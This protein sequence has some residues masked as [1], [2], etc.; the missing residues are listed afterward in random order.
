MIFE[1]YGVL[2]MIEC[3]FVYIVMLDAFW[4]CR[5]VGIIV[6]VGRWWPGNSNVFPVGLWAAQFWIIL[7]LAD[8]APGMQKKLSKY[9]VGS[10]FW[11]SLKNAVI[12]VAW[13]R[14]QMTLIIKTGFSVLLGGGN[15]N[16][17]YVHPENWGRWTHLDSYVSKGLVQPPTS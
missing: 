10:R 8:D 14:K 4:C 9:C 13:L 3:F 5:W 11:E 15:S 1:D 12:T 17:F 7:N 6:L 2:L 16:I